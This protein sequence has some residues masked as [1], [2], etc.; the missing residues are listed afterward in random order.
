M[1]EII[2][3]HTHHLYENPFE[4]ILNCTPEVYLREGSGY[5]SVGYHPWYLSP[6][7]TENWKLFAQ[8]V[9]LPHVLAIGEA[10]LDK[11][12]DTPWNIQQVAFEKQA[13]IASQLRKPLIIHC[14]KAFNEII[15][16]HKQLKSDTPW[17]IHGFRGKKELAAQL[18]E[19]GFYL[20]F[21]EKYQIEALK[22]VPLNRMFMETDESEVDIQALY[23]RAAIHLNMDSKKLKE[24]IQQS[25]KNVFNYSP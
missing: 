15:S 25:I 3:I 2:D 13:K 20:S 19:H 12:T 14:V 18:L 10:G 23:E 9:S 6:N 17:I 7:A 16:Y 11:L 8:I 5:C 1:M 21:G 24:E 4:A 22:I